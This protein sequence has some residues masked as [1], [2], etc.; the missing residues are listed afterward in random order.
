MVGM[1]IEGCAGPSQGIK[2]ILCP[3]APDQSLLDLSDHCPRSTPHLISTLTLLCPPC[4]CP[5]GDQH[6]KAGEAGG[7]LPQENAG[8]SAPTASSVHRVGGEGTTMY[9]E[10]RRGGL[11][12]S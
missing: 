3:P 11:L 12:S 7:L 6:G 1:G 2:G 9:A 5:Q 8:P 4:F 10:G